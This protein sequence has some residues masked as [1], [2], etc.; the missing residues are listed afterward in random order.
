LTR[1]AVLIQMPILLGAVILVNTPFGAESEFA[2]SLLILLLL[3][4][5]FIEG[6]GPFSL[7]NYFAKHPK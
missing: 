2:F 4:F 7:D 3:I 6:G 1:W 5:F